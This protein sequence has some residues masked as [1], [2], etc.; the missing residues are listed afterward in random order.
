M[1]LS[2]PPQYGSLGLSVGIL[3]TVCRGALGFTWFILLELTVRAGPGNENYIASPLS[4][5]QLAPQHVE[6]ILIGR[7]HKLDCDVRLFGAQDVLGLKRTP[8]LT[9]DSHMAFIG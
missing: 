7:S 1:L 9:I 6:I 8:N 2:F 5:L 3:Q 4:P